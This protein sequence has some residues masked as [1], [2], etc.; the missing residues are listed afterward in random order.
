MSVA[1]FSLY[2]E[3]S[4]ATAFSY[5]FVAVSEAGRGAVLYRDDFMYKFVCK[6]LLDEKFCF[7]GGRIA[8]IGNFL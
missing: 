5:L 1:F 6:Q 7:H 3:L 8:R 2:R 4:Q